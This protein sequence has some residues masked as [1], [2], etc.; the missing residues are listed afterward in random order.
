MAFSN[1]SKLNK[2]KQRMSEPLGPIQLRFNLNEKHKISDLNEQDFT[3][4]QT[5]Y[6][7]FGERLK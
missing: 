4:M 6:N 7:Q 3:N 1:L 2:I 5:K